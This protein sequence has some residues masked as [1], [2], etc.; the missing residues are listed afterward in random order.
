[1]PQSRAS[2][3][4]SGGVTGTS[5][6]SMEMTMRVVFAGAAVVFVLVG[7]AAEASQINTGGETGAYQTTFCPRLEE[8]L[9]KNKFDYQCTPSEGSRENIQRSVAD[10]SQ[11]GYS[12]LDIFYLEAENLGRN[13]LYTEVRS[14]FARECLFMV[15]RNRQIT[16]YGQV[17]AAAGQLRFVLPPAKSGS[18]GTF[19]FLQRIDPDGIGLAQEIVYADS[20]DDAINEALAA[21]D[22][23]T[24]FVQFPDPNNARFKSIAKQGGNIVP[25]IDRKILRQEMNGQKIY[26]AEETE[27]NLPKWSKSADKVVTACTPMVLF[28][29][30]PGLIADGNLRKDQEDLVRTVQALPLEDLRPKE[31]FFAK[32]WKKTKSLSA[33]S[34]EKMLKLSEDARQQAEPMLKDAMTKAKEMT[35]QAKQQAQELI[36]KAKTTMEQQ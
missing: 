19:E 18:A 4:A 6:R 25:V 24:L 20:T 1:M 12:Q 3:G 8:A 36:D 33:Q 10:P 16:N 28:A 35:E 13:D 14:D 34:V 9:R 29:G 2:A 31:G 5:G 7:A 11:I 22:L 23:V 26:F 17:A 30:A 27:I 15:T 32:I 21:D